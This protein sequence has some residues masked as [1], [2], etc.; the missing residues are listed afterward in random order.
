MGGA[1]F[2]STKQVCTLYPIIVL[3]SFTNP[4]MIWVVS[5]W[6]AAPWNLSNVAKTITYQLSSFLKMITESLMIVSYK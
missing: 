5:R 4:D 2:M 3:K 1:E 6:A